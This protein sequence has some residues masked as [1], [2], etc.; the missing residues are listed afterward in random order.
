MK[1]YFTISLL[2]V[3]FLSFTTTS[4]ASYSDILFKKD[5]GFGV[6]LFQT[7]SITYLEYQGKRIHTQSHFSS[8]NPFVWDEWCDELFTRLKELPSE[9]M[10]PSV[11][12]D[13]W[14]EMWQDK[15]QSCV[16]E[17]YR[18]IYSVST[19]ENNYPYDNRFLLIHKF[20]YEFEIIYIFDT[21]TKKWIGNTSHLIPRQIQIGSSAT[22]VLGDIVRGWS[23]NG[24][25]IFSKKGEEIGSF[26]SSSLEE[27]I[28]KETDQLYISTF[29]L[30]PKKTI[31][32]TYALS[33]WSEKKTFLWKPFQ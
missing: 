18:K 14:D 5:L 17:W 25:I 32:V 22:Y 8:E 31:K 24:I 15:Q 3:S 23:G 6:T 30:L 9:S 13:I 20:A 12:Q 29:E 11:K 27:I 26:D 28:G 19:L 4:F 33:E 2:I 7:K 21:K 16:R 10:D 1:I